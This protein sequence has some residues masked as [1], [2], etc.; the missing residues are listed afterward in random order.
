MLEFEQ[1]PLQVHHCPEQHPVQIFAPDRA[2]QPLDKWMGERHIRNGLYFC[3]LQ[4]P[5]IGLPLVEAIQRIMIRAQIPRQAATSNRVIEHPAQSRTVYCSP[6]DPKPND[7]PRKLI[8]H[9][10]DPM[11]R[12]RCRFA[13]KQITTP[14]AVLQMT[15]KRQPR[16]AGIRVRPVVNAQDSAN[17]VLIDLDAKSQSNLLGDSRQPQPG[18][19]RFISATAVMSSLLGPFG[20]G[21][22]RTLDE[23]NRRYFLFRRRSWRCNSVD[24]FKVTADRMSRARR[25]KRAQ[26]PTMIRSSE[27]RFG[28][29]FRLRLRIWS[30]CLIR[31]DSATTDRMPPGRVSR[32][33]VTTK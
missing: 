5:Q 6:V 33:I 17:Y 7:P 25:M 4:Y 30:W 10:Q 16:W 28:A 18:L 1:L 11:G 32:A 14:Q 13:P 3:D 9:D 22:R 23:N 27:R 19:R 26:K 31:I 20:P 21:R 24:G 8:H 12:Q 15:E 29:R 2:D